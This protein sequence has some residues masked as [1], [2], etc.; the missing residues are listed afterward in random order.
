M[1]ESTA[2]EWYASNLLI[3]SDNVGPFIYYTHL[4]P[5]IASLFLGF[6][7]LW[8]S[9]K[10]LV[11]WV[12]FFMTLMFSTWVY[13][14]LILW[15]SPSP[16]AVMFF[17]S[18][19]VPIEML[20][21]A[22]GLYL[23]YLFSN[24]QKDISLKTKFLI[25][26]FFI[27]IVLF[28]HT[29]YNLLG[30]SPDCDEGA[31]EGP[32][33]QYMYMVE[34]LFI[35]WAGVVAYMGFRRYADEHKKKQLLTVSIGTIA[36]LLSFTAGNLTLIFSTGPLYEQYKLFGM[37]IFA[38]FIA[39]SIV[40]FKT[41]NAKV[42]SAQVL[43][44]ALGILVFSLLALQS[45]DAV[46]YVTA[47]TFVL[48]C[49]IGFNLVKSVRHEID[50]RELIEAQEKELQIVNKQQENLLRFI[51]HEVKGYLAKS[52]AAF[53]GIVQG[54]YGATTPQ[55]DA[56]ARAGLTDMK[57][58]VDMV[59]DILDASNLRKGT[60]S[61]EKKMFDFKR[62]VE[63]VVQSSREMFEKKGL[64]LE[65]SFQKGAY[66]FTGDETKLRRHLIRNLVDNALHYTPSGSVT[67]AL[68]RVGNVIRFSVKDTGVGITTGDMK[69]L[70]TEGGHGK[71]S[72]KVN[73]DS[74]GYGLFIAKQITQAHGGRIWV[75]SK[76]KG[77]GSEFI[78]ELPVSA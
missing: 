63:D 67:V 30:L 47:A 55:L 61:Y 62:M 18:T 58:G 16:E 70:F 41:F 1:E 12:L 76:G 33:I 71:E 31:I 64:A 11:H 50:Q 20:I 7:V 15:A 54:D 66:A 19:I 14:D 51:G 75:E 40:K 25:G 4:L 2:C 46:R 52:E 8:S 24:D 45:L 72:L 28:T 26:A 60:V 57:K 35:L 10:K 5:L 6:F 34:I 78:V 53:A 13:F 39:Y 37:P 48:V 27:P 3:V 68:S 65:V 69:N 36:F 32:L 56:M 73:V 49:I 17:W 29:Q 23:V 21:Y 9:G 77:Q 42:F 59:G 22:S 38:A 44:L 43:V 74:T